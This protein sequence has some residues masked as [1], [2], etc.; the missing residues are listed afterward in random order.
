MKNT[1]AGAI[2]VAATLLLPQ[3]SVAG[4]YMCV[5]PV[6]GKK[7]FT[8]RACPTAKAGQKVR[9]EPTNFGG[10]VAKRKSRG[11]WSKDQDRSVSGRANLADKPRVATSVSG[12]G[13][14]GA[15]S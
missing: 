8:D 5:D 14:L 1:L 11:T 15:G 6:T 9:V 13:M 7:S 10:G 12:N 2:L 3:V 4:V